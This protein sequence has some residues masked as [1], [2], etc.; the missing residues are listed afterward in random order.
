MIAVYRF[1]DEL[2]GQI[3]VDLLQEQGIEATIHSWRD[4]AYDGLRLHMAATG[5]ILVGDEHEEKARRIITEYH[6][7]LPTP[8]TSDPE[9]L[10]L[11]A[12]IA[13]KSLRLGQFMLWTLLPAMVAIGIWLIFRGG[14]QTVLFGVTLLAVAGLF[15]WGFSERKRSD[16]R[17]IQAAAKTDEANDHTP[18]SAPDKPDADTPHS[19]KG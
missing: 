10:R 5:E 9:T 13:R 14:V 6:E 18:K 4:T 12:E 7:S 16:L 15:F 8:V 17:T 2:E 19:P 3:L 11:K 1:S